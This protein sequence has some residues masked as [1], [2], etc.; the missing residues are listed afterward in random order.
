MLI[1]SL[2]LNSQV[3][4]LIREYI[5]NQILKEMLGLQI[6]LGVISISMVLIVGLKQRILL[7][8]KKRIVDWAQ[9][10]S[11]CRRERGG[12]SKV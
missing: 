12:H 2:L 11:I 5:I 10:D 8:K 1:F 4:Q 9:R 3:E 6:N 7:D